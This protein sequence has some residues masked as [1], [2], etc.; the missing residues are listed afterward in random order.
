MSR[1]ERLLRRQ[2]RFGSLVKGCSISRTRRAEDFSFS[3]LRFI[4]KHAELTEEVFSKFSAPLISLCLCPPKTR[5]KY[6]AIDRASFSS[7][8]RFLRRSSTPLPY[9]EPWRLLL[10]ESLSRIPSWN[11]VGF[12]L[13]SLDP[14]ASLSPIAQNCDLL[15]SVSDTPRRKTPGSLHLTMH[16][17]LVLP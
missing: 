11:Q 4:R 10:R 1:A 5:L 9:T 7:P 2:V 8:R 6:I 14:P 17:L 16:I 12:R 3:I 15:R 13:S